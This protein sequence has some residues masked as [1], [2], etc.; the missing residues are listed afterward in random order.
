MRIC[1]FEDPGAAN[2]GPLA[3][4]RPVF[5]LR[6]GVWTL[7]ERQRR[8]AVGLGGALV[9]PDLADMC[10]LTHPDLAVNDA[11]WLRDAPVLL[12]NGR[13]LPPASTPTLPGA[14]EVGIVG[15]EVAYVCLPHGGAGAWPSGSRPC[16]SA[17]RAAV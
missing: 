3:L 5:D 13:W 12:V 10:R 11:D 15:D 6:C 7:L 17:R 8:L 14:G 16:G 9:R 2:L 4:T 1:V